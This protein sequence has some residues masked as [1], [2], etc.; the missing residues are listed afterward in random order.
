MVNVEMVG[1]G[2]S[3]NWPQDGGGPGGQ[4][5]AAEMLNVLYALNGWGVLERTY[6]F[7]ITEA[8]RVITIP[9]F[10]AKIPDGSGGYKNVTQAG[11]N[12]TVTAADGTNPRTDIVV[13]DSAGVLAVTAGTATAETGDVK[14]APM[15]AL[16]ADEIFLVKC[17]V[18]ANQTN[19]LTAD[20]FGRAID[21]GEAQ[22][23]GVKGSDIA[24]ASTITLPDTNEDRFDITGTVTITAVSARRAGSRVWFQFDAATPITHNVTSLILLDGVSYTT[25]AGDAILFECIDGT[26][27]KELSRN[28]ALNTTPGWNLVGSQ[29]TEA[30]TTSTSAVDLLTVAIASTPA[31]VPLMIAG[32]YRKTGGAADDAHLGLKLNTTVVSEAE[33]G[34]GRGLAHSGGGDN[35]E[36]GSFVAYLGP[37]V[38][39]YLR[40][41]TGTHSSRG[42]T[43]LTNDTS[44]PAFTADMPTAAITSVI[45]RGITDNASNTLGVTEVFV[46]ALGT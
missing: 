21:V 17:K 8:D 30:T 13:C 26:N 36:S 3:D 43:A 46:Y 42:S 16:A 6:T 14:E 4:F 29:T 15:P 35:A 12:V 33:P 9:A 23:N 27:W 28:T 31:T 32:S 44:G 20:V 40:G 7:T 18:P 45:I 37:R 25:I 5:H 24:S 22:L 10:E 19:V 34:S 1:Q 38:T 2:G 11:G 41:A 39:N